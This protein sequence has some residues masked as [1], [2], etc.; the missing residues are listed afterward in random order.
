MPYGERMSTASDWKPIVPLVGDGDR[1][2]GGVVAPTLKLEQRPCVNC[3]AFEK[4]P[5]R[6]E[7][8]FRAHGLTIDNGIVTT[9]IAKNF[10]G[11]K[12]M[13]IDLAIMGWCRLEVMPVDE[14]ASCQRW[15]PV[16]RLAAIL[17]GVAKE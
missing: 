17:G 14:Q 2:I 1:E 13:K 16:S 7:R 9:P 11:R 8:H 5:E 15:V 3:R 6:L 10:P 12:S 4:E